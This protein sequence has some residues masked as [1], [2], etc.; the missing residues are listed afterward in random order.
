MSDFQNLKKMPDSFYRM[1]IEMMS[2]ENSSLL[3][4]QK[5]LEGQYQVLLDN[6]L[7]DFMRVLEEQKVLVWEINQKEEIRK[8]E[9]NSFLTNVEEISLQE[10]IQAA[11]EQFQDDLYNLKTQFDQCIRTIN[12]MRERNHILIQ[13]SLEMV[14]QQIQFLCSFGRPGYT[15]SGKREE[16]DLS[17]FNKRA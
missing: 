12:E 1:M 10:I 9:L 4:L 5:N 7:S 13:K 2:T 16:N 8:Q 6:R 15:A 3:Q 17:I 14:H 11:P